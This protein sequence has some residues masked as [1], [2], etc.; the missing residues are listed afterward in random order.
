M[1]LRLADGLLGF[2]ASSLW[3]LTEELICIH[4]LKSLIKTERP[5]CIFGCM[6]I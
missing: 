2:H 6:I 1:T 5:C 4:L 3:A